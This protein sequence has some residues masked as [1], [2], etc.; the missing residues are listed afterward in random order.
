ML[1]PPALHLIEIPSYC[2]YQ[3]ADDFHKSMIFYFF[4]S[5][6][7]GQIWPAPLCL[8]NCIFL[9]SNANVIVCTFIVLPVLVCSSL[10]IR[11]GGLCNAAVLRNTD[12]PAK[13]SL[14]NIIDFLFVTYMPLCDTQTHYL[15]YSLPLHETA[16]SR[17]GQ[18]ESAQNSFS[19]AIAWLCDPIYADTWD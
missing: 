10:Y 4:L 8:P 19:A 1:F 15:V 16:V 13:S 6:N 12:G 5:E 3:W 11:M 18:L 17:G 9:L 7:V 14:W 2:E